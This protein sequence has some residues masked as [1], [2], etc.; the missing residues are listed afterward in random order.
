MTTNEKPPFR[1]KRR[2]DGIWLE[3]SGKTNDCA[4]RL[5]LGHG[6]IVTNAVLEAMERQEQSAAST[7]EMKITAVDFNLVLERECPTC[8]GVGQMSDERWIQWSLMLSRE[9]PNTLSDLGKVFGLSYEDWL[10]THP[11]PAGPEEPIC[12]ECDGQKTILTEAGKKVA[13]LVHRLIRTS[14]VSAWI[15]E[16]NRVKHHSF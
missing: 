11:Q 13:A 7:D 12:S 1:V 9:F 4:I 2:E 15:T 3:V 5:D 6:A 16:H 14:E 8:G 10:A